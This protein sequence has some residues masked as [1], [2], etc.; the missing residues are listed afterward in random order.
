MPIPRA[1][2][3]H[4]SAPSRRARSGRL[5]KALRSWIL[6]FALAFAILAPLRSAIA[7]WNDV[8]TGSME[9]TILPG[10]RIFVNKLAY[11]L[12]VPFTH[13]WMAQWGGP[14]AGDIVVLDS[15]KDG[16][17]LVKRV[18]AGPGDTVELRNN[19]LVINGV[20][21]GYSPLPE[22]SLETVPGRLRTGR[23]FATER[24]GTGSHAIEATPAISRAMRTFPP[25]T[26][27]AGQYF[28]MGDNRDNSADSRYFGFVKREQIVG[29][30]SAVAV[31][32]DPENWYLPR[33]G[34]WFM[35]LR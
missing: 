35:G 8:P 5:L 15:P 22:S 28:V 2:S 1:Q 10:D 9:P 24:L 31:S 21:R 25:R 4:P 11:G 3:A 6:S 34:R 19:V 12:R 30:S 26:V 14:Q 17:R 32:V 16:T 7:D 18:A 23:I 33:F 29:R 20:A 27:P 13:S